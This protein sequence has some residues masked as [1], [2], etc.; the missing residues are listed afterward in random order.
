MLGK[1]NKSAK[2]EGLHRFRA[3]A[4]CFNQTLDLNFWS[5]ISFLKKI[6][7]KNKCMKPNSLFER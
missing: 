1:K 5:R 7:T 2:I 6:E 3:L 4:S